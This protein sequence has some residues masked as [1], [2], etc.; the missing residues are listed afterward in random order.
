MNEQELVRQL[1][2]GSRTAFDRIYELYHV[3]A[4]RT[5]VF[6][7]GSRTDAEDVVQEAFVQVYLHAGELKEPA[8]FKSWFYRILT[9]LAWKC[10]REGR[11][12]IPDED[13][14]IR[15][16]QADEGDGLSQL[17]GKEERE[18]IRRAVENLDEKHRSIVV[19]Y[20]FNDFTTGEIAR[21]TGCFEGT[22]KSR[23]YAARK[24][25]EKSLAE[26][27]C[28]RER[29][30]R[31]GTEGGAAREAGKDAPAGHPSYDGL[32][33]LHSFSAEAGHGGK[34][35]KEKS[36]GKNCRVVPHRSGSDPRS[37]RHESGA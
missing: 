29:P 18:R 36:G 33:N 34:H 2:M 32:E 12:E 23:L 6:L 3:Q 37:C 9:R 35:G 17:L 20:Y 27:G 24:K 15:A 11:R 4:Y 13:I 5:A 14:S 21:I 1:Q 26:E 16:D 31:K 22:V 25:L 28:G 7:T 30:G 8:G 19:L 10:G